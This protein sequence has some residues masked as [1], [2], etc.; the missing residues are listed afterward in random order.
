MVTLHELDEHLKELAD[1]LEKIPAESG[2]LM[3]N[4]ANLLPRRN[5]ANELIQ[6]RFAAN[7][8]LEI[9]VDLR[10]DGT[11]DSG[12]FWVLT[13]VTVAPPN[14][15]ST[16][17]TRVKNLAAHTTESRRLAVIPA[18]DVP[19]RGGSICVAVHMDPPQPNLPAG[20]VLE[21]NVA[22]NYDRECVAIPPTE[23]TPPR[24]GDRHLQPELTRRDEP[25]AVEPVPAQDAVRGGVG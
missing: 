5:F 14:A 11:R 1:R 10:N 23:V 12:P 18:A 25:A 7:G 9:H 4:L 2:R 13:T 17:F 21:S 16:A 19:T 20:E 24:P 22:D 6:P 8:D 15:T 3:L